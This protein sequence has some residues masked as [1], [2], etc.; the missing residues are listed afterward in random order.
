VAAG[1]SGRVSVLPPAQVPVGSAEPPWPTPAE[2][3]LA[4]LG[5]AMH[6]SINGSEA[7]PDDTAEI[8]AK[9]ADSL[10]AVGALPVTSALLHQPPGLGPGWH[11]PLQNRW[12]RR[13]HQRDA[14]FRPSEHRGLA[15]RLPLRH[16]TAV[17]ESVS[18]RDE[19]VSINLYG[20]PWVTGEYWPMITPCFQVHA[21][22]DAGLQY[23]G[24]GGDWHGLPGHAGR[25]GFWLWPPVSPDRASLR[26]TV[27]TLWE[28]AWSEIDLPR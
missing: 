25:G 3:Y 10:M 1:T 7:G 15:A 16:A 8:I 13:V 28:A 6:I 27:S 22:D 23:E 12:G 17:I 21:T 2:C 19:L 20:H 9:V 11:A 5:P 24:V 14:A 18:A 4:A 26:V